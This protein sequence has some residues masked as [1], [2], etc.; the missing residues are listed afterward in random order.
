MFK[1]TIKLKLNFNSIN[2]RIINISKVIL[3]IKKT[4]FQEL[5]CFFLKLSKIKMFQIC[6]IGKA[7]MFYKHHDMIYQHHSYYQCK[8]FF[9]DKRLLNIIIMETSLI[10]GTMLLQ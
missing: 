3:Y 6:F 8:N 5:Q 1:G 4:L 7:N 2:L 10:K 9:L